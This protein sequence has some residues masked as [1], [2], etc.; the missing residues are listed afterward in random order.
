MR[1]RDLQLLID[2]LR[3]AATYEQGVMFKEFNQAMR[4]LQELGFYLSQEQCDIINDLRRTADARLEA[5]VTGPG[6]VRILYND[7]EPD[8]ACDHT[9]LL[10]D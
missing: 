6:I 4:A 8:S 2:Q 10:D 1:R 5:A 3:M 7:L 9:Y